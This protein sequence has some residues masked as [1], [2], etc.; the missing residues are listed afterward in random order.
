M[1]SLWQLRACS[2]INSPWSKLWGLRSLILFALSSSVPLRELHDTSLILCLFLSLTALLLLLVEVSP[3]S[4]VV[5]IVNL[6]WVL[7]SFWV[8]LY[9]VLQDNLCLLSSGC[10]TSDSFWFLF[11]AAAGRADWYAW[12]CTLGCTR[13]FLMNVYSVASCRTHFEKF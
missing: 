13:L 7:N 5:R 6:F 3:L 2:P 11:A 12:P 4:Q 10:A 9:Y 8:C 1:T